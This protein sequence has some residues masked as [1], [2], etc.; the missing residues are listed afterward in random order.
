ML[1]LG[2]CRG[3]SILKNSYYSG[4]NSFLFLLYPVPVI[5]YSFYFNHSRPGIERKAHSGVGTRTCSVPIA[6]GSPARSGP[7]NFFDQLNSVPPP[8]NVSKNPHLASGHKIFISSSC[9]SLILF[10]ARDQGHN[11]FRLLGY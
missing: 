11:F 8:K 7:P 4:G 5:T 3:F 9:L 2:L 10:S 6:I 1:E